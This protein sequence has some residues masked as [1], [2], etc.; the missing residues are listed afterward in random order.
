MLMLILFSILHNYVFTIS[1]WN[2]YD[3]NILF[4]LLSKIKV[5]TEILDE[6]ENFSG[7]DELDIELCIKNESLKDVLQH[8]NSESDCQRDTSIRFLRRQINR[9]R[10][11]MKCITTVIKDWPL[12]CS[13]FAG[14]AYQMEPNLKVI[15]GTIMGN[16]LHVDFATNSS[17]ST[18]NI[19]LMQ[20]L[21]ILF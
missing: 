12:T 10:D 14:S 11:S 6:I 17:R 18:I 21:S 13:V 19:R 1:S 2:C 7:N 4:L 15:L 8:E 5:K 3:W 20:K 9:Y 16:F